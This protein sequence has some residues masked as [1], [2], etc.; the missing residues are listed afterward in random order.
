ME[1]QVALS[2]LL[3]MNTLYNSARFF[4]T[5]FSYMQHLGHGGIA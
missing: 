2:A 5:P 1:G 3:T 4:K